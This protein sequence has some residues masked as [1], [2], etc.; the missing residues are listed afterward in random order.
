MIFI[1]GALNYR[2]TVR[3]SKTIS[4][5]RSFTAI[6]QWWLFNERKPRH[7]CTNDD[8]ADVVGEGDSNER[9]ISTKSL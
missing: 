6:D 7:R 8:G 1:V 2:Y 3:M 5:F 4:I 9:V